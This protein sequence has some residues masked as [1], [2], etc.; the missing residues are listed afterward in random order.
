MDLDRDL[1]CLAPPG[2]GLPLH[3]VRPAGL[4]ALLAA[5]SDSGPSSGPAS[6][7][8]A[9][10]ARASG[11]RAEPGQLVLLPG[12]DG[13]A[14]ALL[15]LGEDRSPWAFG[16]LATALPPG[17]DWH[18]APGDYDGGAAAL[19]FCLGAYRF[20]AFKAPKPIARLAPPPG[21]DPPLA[22]LSAEPADA[23]PPLSPP[24]LFAAGAPPVRCAFL[25]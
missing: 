20:A 24:S 17:T 21:A 22:P 13:L 15:G 10:F 7:P 25:P 19:G 6:G 1:D 3:P 5:L 8:A 11:F 23:P 16:G 18:L 4:D 2:A 12:R 14:G 9:A